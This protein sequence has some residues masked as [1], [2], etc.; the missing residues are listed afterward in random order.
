MLMQPILPAERG[1]LVRIEF[2]VAA[3]P[4]LIEGPVNRLCGET[5]QEQASSLR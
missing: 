2:K 4:G 1:H 5:D 3:E